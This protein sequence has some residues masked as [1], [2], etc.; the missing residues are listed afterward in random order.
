MTIT[1]QISTDDR[2]ALW[3]R[4]WRTEGPPA[5]ADRYVARGAGISCT[6]ASPGDA[7]EKLMGILREKYKGDTLTVTMA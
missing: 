5:D 2:L 7:I 3:Q 1:I 6:A 4:S